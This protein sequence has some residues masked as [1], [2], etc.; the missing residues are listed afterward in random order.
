[1][2]FSL[3]QSLVNPEVDMQ[4]S[5]LIGFFSSKNFFPL[6]GIFSLFCSGL[7]LVLAMASKEHFRIL[8]RLAA[9]AVII[10][11]IVPK[12][13]NHESSAAGIFVAVLMLLHILSRKI[14]KPWFI[15]N[16]LACLSFAVY[17]ICDQFDFSSHRN[18]VGCLIFIGTGC[19][20]GLISAVIIKS[21]KIIAARI[22]S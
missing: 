5:D 1:L 22:D 3:N 4:C 20:T 6:L 7:F 14:P 15:V 18:L 17:L 8:A 11:L 13:I 9:A 10:L 12:L 16:L 21:I 19:F 2:I